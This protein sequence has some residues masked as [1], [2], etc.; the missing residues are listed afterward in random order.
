MG[1]PAVRTAAGASLAAPLGKAR[2]RARRRAAIHVG[3]K[4]GVRAGGL[5]AA[6]APSGADQQWLGD[7]GIDGDG[8]PG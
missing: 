6:V 1:L 4:G 3:G 8:L 7:I 5:T 2:A